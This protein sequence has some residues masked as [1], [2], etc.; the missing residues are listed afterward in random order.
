M[1]YH[2]SH[3]RAGSLRRLS[4]DELGAYAIQEELIDAFEA[5]DD[6]AIITQ[7][8]HRFILPPRQASTFLIGMLRGRSWYVDDPAAPAPD[9]KPIRRPAALRPSGR[10]RD[11]ES[12][13]ERSG[14][15]PPLD[16][17]LRSLLAFTR[18]VGIIEG[19]DRDD[20][21][22]T[23]RI[24]IAACSTNLSYTDAVDY[25]FDCIQEEMRTLKGRNT[26]GGSPSPRT[27][28]Q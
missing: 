18:E 27:N 5:F 6:R 14:G 15:Q 22:R 26:P 24:D 20:E 7:G 21:A 19:Y 3:A 2:D 17:T 13:A 25:L 28:E 1:K 10:E 9:A 16:M 23:V 11:Q 8:D 4:I 12:G